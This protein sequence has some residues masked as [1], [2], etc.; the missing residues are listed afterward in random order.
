MHLHQLPNSIP[1]LADLLPKLNHQ[2]LIL[3]LHMFLSGQPVLA[4]VFH[5]P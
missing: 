3:L 5:N 4:V 2:H 1:G